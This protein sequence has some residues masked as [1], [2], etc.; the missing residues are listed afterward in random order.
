MLGPAERLALMATPGVFEWYIEGADLAASLMSMGLIDEAFYRRLILDPTKGIARQAHRVGLAEWSRRI[1][2]MGDATILVAAASTV[3]GI[4][5]A[6]GKPVMKREYGIDDRPLEAIVREPEW[7]EGEDLAGVEKTMSDGVSL[8]PDRVMRWTTND[9]GSNLR[10]RD[11]QD[12]MIRAQRPTR[13]LA[14]PRPR[15]VFT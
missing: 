7:A 13:G 12:E 2:N 9:D 6:T 11:L 5:K 10:V 15:P 14:R 8:H 4:D 1:Y 3:M